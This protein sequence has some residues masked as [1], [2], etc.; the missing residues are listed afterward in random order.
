M[1]PAPNVSKRS[2][3]S[4]SRIAVKSTTRSTASADVVG[5][6]VGEAVGVRFGVP[7]GLGCAVAVDVGFVGLGDGVGVAM[8]I[9]VAADE[10]AAM[11]KTP[12]MTVVATRECDER[13]LFP[14]ARRTRGDAQMR[15]LLR[16]A[17]GRPTLAA[18]THSQ[19]SNRTPSPTRTD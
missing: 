12:A 7:T 5:S 14:S 2:A 16:Q 13:M 6:A 1:E 8:G 9:E 3:W 18:V 4:T 17:A 11:T 19:R 15:R 10:Q